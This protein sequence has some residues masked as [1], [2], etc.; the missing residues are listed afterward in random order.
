VTG[1]VKAAVE[2]E[3]KADEIEVEAPSIDH[4]YADLL[5]LLVVLSG[6]KCG[7]SPFVR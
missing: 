2:V 4:N 7:R 3:F 5:L 6:E 1:E